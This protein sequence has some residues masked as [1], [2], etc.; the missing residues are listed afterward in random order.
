MKNKFIKSKRWKIWKHKTVFLAVCLMTICGCT[1]TKDTGNRSKFVQ[2]VAGRMH[3]VALKE[4]GTLL[5]WG[6]N[7][8]YQ[9]DNDNRPYFS[10]PQLVTTITEIKQIAAGYNY[11]VILKKMAQYGHGEVIWVDS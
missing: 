2:V 1:V 5:T 7:V 10:E 11:T 4:D 3:T 8:N 9:I 6:A